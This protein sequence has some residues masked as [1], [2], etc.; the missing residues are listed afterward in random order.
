M[1]ISDWSSDVCSSDLNRQPLR[2]NGVRG[3]GWIIMWVVKKN[4]PVKPNKTRAWYSYESGT[5]AGWEPVPTAPIPKANIR[6]RVFG[7]R[8][9]ALSDH[10]FTF[11]VAIP[12][13]CLA[14]IG[15]YDRFPGPGTSGP[16]TG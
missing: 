7:Y 15:I 8:Y 3:M 12:R 4:A 10:V 13:P 16:G 11:S 5:V 2:P 6:N 14:L 9:L 1:R